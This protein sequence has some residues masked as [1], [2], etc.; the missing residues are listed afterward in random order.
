[1]E[2][3]SKKLEELPFNESCGVASPKGNENDWNFFVKFL[4]VIHDPESFKTANPELAKVMSQIRRFETSDERQKCQLY[5][6]TTFREF[7]KVFL[8]VLHHFDA[9]LKKL[10]E[11][12]NAW[13][14]RLVEKVLFTVHG[15]QNL[16]NGSAL[17]LHLRNIE[18]ILND[19]PRANEQ[20]REC[21]N[22]NEH[23][24]DPDERDEDLEA[25]HPS[26]W[27]QAK[28][29]PARWKSYRKWLKIMLVHFDAMDVL[30]SHASGQYFPHDDIKVR[31]LVPRRREEDS[32]LLQWKDLFGNPALFPEVGSNP[33]NADISSFLG[34]S[35]TQ[36][37][38]RW[39]RNVQIAWVS[40]R[41][42]QDW[43]SVRA[44]INDWN[45]S[46][47]GG[48]ED[49][50]RRLTE[51]LDDDRHDLFTTIIDSLVAAGRLLNKINSDALKFSGT[52]HCEA[53]LASYLLRDQ[54]VTIDDVGQDTL[55]HTK[56]GNAVSDLLLPSDLHFLQ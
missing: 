42:S 13:K 50:V 47:L 7:H 44:K 55:D 41:K 48:W 26:A 14:P 52:L 45:G 35:F 30:G 27:A 46:Q 6:K 1:L 19:P 16:C 56:V 25:I 40:T 49:C 43:A 53:C 24:A 5:S 20:S 18:G 32:K 11:S 23:N 28:E 17:K 33:T 39:A 36:G 37:D 8:A 9:E 38:L 31:V 3:S 51:A 21:E 22:F 12:P 29:Q 34:T 54:D 2:E 10:E 4:P 15:L